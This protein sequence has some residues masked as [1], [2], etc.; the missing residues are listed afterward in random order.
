MVRVDA[1]I[2]P[3]CAE[4]ACLNAARAWD[5]NAWGCALRIS[6]GPIAMLTGV[7]LASDRA[8]CLASS[9]L[10]LSVQQWTT[11]R[12]VGPRIEG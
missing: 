4:R 3:G 11:G 8:R 10:Q 9:L 7:V 6:A 12:L 5:G 2:P 1:A